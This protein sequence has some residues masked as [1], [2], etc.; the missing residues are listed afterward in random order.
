MP[1]RYQNS[2]NGNGTFITA[3]K[4]LSFMDGNKDKRKNWQSR[5]YNGLIKADGHQKGD[6][7]KIIMADKGSNIQD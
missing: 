2:S 6:F 5:R 7:L 4:Y 1:N 3:P